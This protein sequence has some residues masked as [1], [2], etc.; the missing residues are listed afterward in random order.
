M[1]QRKM[2][3]RLSLIRYG[4]PML[5]PLAALAACV[6]GLAMDGA[7]PAAHEATHF[8]N[9]LGSSSDASISAAHHEHQA[10]S[11]YSM[12]QALVEAE[13]SLD[14]VEAGHS[15][16]TS[17]PNEHTPAPSV[18]DPR[19]CHLCGSQHPSVLLANAADLCRLCRLLI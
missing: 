4:M 7:R 17:W 10:R 13:V 19:G 12:P 11:T 1:R 3:S 14:E 9:S 18:C 6:I 2:I 15:E 16:P 8:C 5:A